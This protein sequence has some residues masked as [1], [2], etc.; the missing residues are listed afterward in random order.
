MRL[1]F[2]KFGR[3]SD[4]PPSIILGDSIDLE[5]I[6]KDLALDAA[7]SYRIVLALKEAIPITVGRI[8]LGFGAGS[9]SF[10]ADQAGAWTIS[11][12][13]NDLD[14]VSS[15]GG[16]TVTGKNGLY[17]VAFVAVGARDAITVSH[18]AIGTL[19]SR[20]RTVVAGSAGAKAVFELDLTVQ[21]LAEDSVFTSIPA[22]TATVEAI[23]TGSVSAF[24]VDRI[25]ISDVS[26]GGM[27]RI[28]VSAGVTTVWMPVGISSYRLELELDAIS[29]GSFLVSRTATAE[30]VAFDLARTSMGVNAP[31]TVQ[32][33]FPARPGIAVTLETGLTK[34][35]IALTDA[36]AHV[37]ILLF[38]TPTETLFAQEVALSPTIADHPAA[39]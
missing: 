3:I 9:A 5:L 28:A 36:A 8:T 15:E 29:E 7:D 37:A 20:C 18:S 22:Q 33:N 27:F 2:D 24:Q 16:V 25:A 4:M 13:L 17:Q 14:A 30:S 19:A 1:T 26:A 35:L 10:R 21:T 31:P 12:A 39:L 38:V 32:S 11:Q 23:S 6:G 34:P